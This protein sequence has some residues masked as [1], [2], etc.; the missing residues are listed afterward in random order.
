M[1]PYKWKASR[2][3]QRNAEHETAVEPADSPYNP[4]SVASSEDPWDVW[5]RDIGYLSPLDES[6]IQLPEQMISDPETGRINPTNI[7]IFQQGLMER[8]VTLC[9]SADSHLP[10]IK[11][12]TYTAVPETREEKARHDQAWRQDLEKSI[13]DPD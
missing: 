12:L 7:D 13:D 8:N 4:C 9:P 10:S 2:K 3:A 11:E 6:T 1:I 5:Y